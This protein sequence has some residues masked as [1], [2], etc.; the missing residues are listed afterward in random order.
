MLAGKDLR[1]VVSDLFMEELEKA[2]PGYDRRVLDL[3]NPTMPE[4]LLGRFD[5][6]ISR[7][8]NEH[9]SDGERYHRNILSLLRH[10]GRA[11]H[12]SAS[13]F[14]L[15]LLANKLIPGAVADKLLDLFAPRNRHQ[16]D[17]FT[18]YYGWC[19]GPTQT[20][21]GKFQS[22]GY[23]VLSYDGYFGH[24]YYREKLPAL[25]VLESMKS[26]FLVKHPNPHLCS[27]VT[28]VLERPSATP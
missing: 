7:M 13:L 5:L 14:T 10:G 3:E 6:I 8:V 4:D 18:A 2:P 19:R 1:Y 11:V 26:A 20:M 28:I 27:Y 17:R 9:I 22:I 23:K 12:C 21:I 25:H 15:P 24:E 16:H